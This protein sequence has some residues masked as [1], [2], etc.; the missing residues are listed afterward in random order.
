MMAFFL[1]MWLLNA[2]T[3]EQRK[4]LADYF[5][6]SIPVHRTSGGG[7][8]PF[9]GASVTSEEVMAQARTGASRTYPTT[10]REAR[11]DT[12]REEAGS[13]GDGA[14]DGLAQA[15]LHAAGES[16]VAERLLQHVRLRR[17]DEGLVIDIMEL[18]NAPLF[19][20][21]TAEPTPRMRELIAFLAPILGLV[22]NRVA[23]DNHLESPAIGSAGG[24]GWQLTSARALSVRELLSGQGLAPS[25]FARVTGEANRAPAFDDPQDIRNRRTEVILLNNQAG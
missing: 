4:G 19:Y 2:T 15:L 9:G 11:G 6:P 14:F 16:A 10:A 24:V 25:R 3:E 7:S 22:T 8:G 12:G 18:P 17:T 21:P 13:D 5:S 23:V 1:L 20:G